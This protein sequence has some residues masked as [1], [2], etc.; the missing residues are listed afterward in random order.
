MPKGFLKHTRQSI[1]ESLSKL[2]QSIVSR[3][4]ANKDHF[5]RGILVGIL[6]S[7][8][9][10]AASLLGYLKPHENFVSDLLQ[11]AVRKKAEN[12]ALVFITEHEYKE[13]FQGIS[14]LSRKR[15]A[16]IVDVLTKLRARVIALDIDL[17]DSTT[18]DQYLL[19]AFDRASASG[20][21]VVVIG[22]LKNDDS[23]TAASERAGSGTLPYRDENLMFT[24]EGH[25]LFDHF[26]PGDT[27][28]NIGR[29]SGVVFQLDRDGVFRKAEAL[30]IIDKNKRGTGNSPFLIPS[31]PVAMAA[32][33]LG[34]NEEY[35]TLALSNP[36]GGL[37]T[38]NPA[39][40]RYHRVQLRIGADG[41]ITPNFIGNYR[42]FEHTVNVAG[43]LDDYG[44]GKPTGMTVFRDK[45]VLIG[46]V[47]DD[48][49]FY[50]TP[51]GRMSGMEIIANITQSIISETLISHMNFY[52]AFIVE[53][54]LGTIVSLIFVLTTRFKATIICFITVIPAVAVA[55][56]ISFAS[57]YYWYDFIPTIAGVVIHGWYK[58]VEVHRQV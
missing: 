6:I 24:N 40:D 27:W 14:P 49:D 42:S 29:H 3:V 55:S 37:I 45:I 1:T 43:L 4:I 9:V 22:S 19:S 26:D 11:S 54:L 52:K 41:R 18:D 28:R 33:Y 12:V 57:L 56:V 39:N 8:L 16:D 25:I 13:G 58:K 53:I 17:S 15:L 5:F 32:A 31:L 36:V 50:M 38:L 44:P 47:Y 51:L 48:K 23:K 21:S 10:T 2:R 7:I 34:V 35:L 20:V 30:Y 46:G